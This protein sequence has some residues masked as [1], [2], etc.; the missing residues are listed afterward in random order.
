MLSKLKNFFYLHWQTLMEI[1]VGLFLVLFAA[2][3]FN[4]CGREKPAPE[5]TPVPEI[6]QEAIKEAILPALS[7]SP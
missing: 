5:V 1:A 4:S 3:V 7:T 6:S 2:I